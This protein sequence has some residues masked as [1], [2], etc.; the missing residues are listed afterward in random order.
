MQ[1][2]V[3]RLLTSHQ[4]EPGLIPSRVASGFLYVRIVPDDAA[5]RQISLGISCF[6]RLFIPALLHTHL[7]SHSSVLKTS[8]LTSHSNLF[9]HLLTICTNSLWYC[10]MSKDV[11]HPQN[12][13]LQLVS[14]FPV[15]LKSNLVP[16]DNARWS[17]KKY[18]SQPA[19]MVYLVVLKFNILSSVATF[20]N[21]QINRSSSQYSWYKYLLLRCMFHGVVLSFLNFSH[22]QRLHAKVKNEARVSP[23]RYS[24]RCAYVEGKVGKR[25]KRE[26]VDLP[27]KLHIGINI[28]N[29]QARPA[30]SKT[31]RMRYR[32]ENCTECGG[33]Y[34][35]SLWHRALV[36]PSNSTHVANRPPSQLSHTGSSGYGSTRSHIKPHHLGLF[37]GSMCSS[38]RV[39]R[40]KRG[41]STGHFPKFYSLRL[42]KK[43]REK[44]PMPE[45]IENMGS[46]DNGGFQLQALPIQEH[47]C[48]DPSEMNNNNSS[49]TSDRR[50]Q[51]N[52][53]FPIPVPA[54]RKQLPNK[55]VRHTYQNVPIPITPNSQELTPPKKQEW[56]RILPAEIRMG[57]P[58]I[59]LVNSRMQIQWFTTAPFCLIPAGAAAMY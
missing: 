7:T 11:R 5:R 57:G 31:P 58:G 36:A 10:V 32:P 37:S 19:T 45:V 50:G 6:P 4:G 15:I 52:A 18:P 56:V 41:Q 44:S 9:T 47:S 16:Q 12:H 17:I 14:S 34:S 49:D 13:Y 29:R 38:L 23:G 55:A 24:A 51:T 53:N 59:K 30:A 27:A 43:S 46:K 25:G 33:L 35:I 3:V 26:A 22:A 54:P 2:V 1:G 20:H 40:H 21:W 48:G 42:R 28:S 8:I 39:N